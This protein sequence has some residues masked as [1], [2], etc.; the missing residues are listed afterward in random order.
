MSKPWAAEINLSIDLARSVISEQF[1]RFANQSLVELGSGWDMI[2]FLV[3]GEYVFRLPRR[4][5]GADLVAIE[6]NVQPRLAPLLPLP[7]PN[8]EFVGRPSDRYPWLFAGYRMIPG[9]T[10]CSR[11]L[12]DSQRAAL[13]PSL[14]S[15]LSTLHSIPPAQVQQLGAPEDLYGRLDMAKR[16]PK[17]IERLESLTKDGLIQDAA[18]LLRLIHETGVPSPNHLKTIVHGD[19]YVR[20][21]VVG[22]DG[23]LT[24]I[25]DWGDVHLGDPAADLSVAFTFLPPGARD[26][27]RSLYGLINETTWKRARFRAINY[28]LLLTDYGHTENDRDILREGQYILSSVCVDR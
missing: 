23:Q 27:F 4:Q 24:G 14:A 17:A 6:I 18:P 3:G 16:I 19:L 25:I 28:G 1:P 7:I 15:F 26:A 21:L 20:H 5:L 8:P 12:S 9:K 10:A 13:I 22:D 2:A 11:N